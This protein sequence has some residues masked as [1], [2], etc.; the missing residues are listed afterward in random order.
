MSLFKFKIKDYHYEPYLD[1]YNELAFKPILKDGLKSFHLSI[2]V[3]EV[4]I[5][6]F[7]SDVIMDEDGNPTEVTKVFLSDGSCVFG[8]NKID[9][10]ELNYTNNYLS[11][12]VTP[13]KGS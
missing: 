12:F 3:N 1:E 11:L 8:A 6:A 4:R 2:D 13:E 7:R 9:S 5:T 10:F